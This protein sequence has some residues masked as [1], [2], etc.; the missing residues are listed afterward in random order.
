MGEEPRSRN[1]VWLWRRLAWAVQAK[2]FGGLSERAKRRIEELIPLAE[3]WMPLGKRALERKLSPTPI[4]KRDPRLPR[5]GTVLT[6]PY[7]GQTLSVMVLEDSFEYEG[8]RY[9]FEESDSRMTTTRIRCDKQAV[10]LFG[11]VIASDGVLCYSR[12]DLPCGKARRCGGFIGRETVQP[13]HV[14]QPVL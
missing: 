8:M 3:T 1:R 2:E 6:R 12:L 5:P 4:P 11:K 9:S 14:I 7:K 10:S 13:N